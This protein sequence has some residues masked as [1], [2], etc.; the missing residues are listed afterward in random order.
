MLRF[1]FLGIHR[2][3]FLFSRCF[4]GGKDGL[5]EEGKT[6]FPSHYTAIIIPGRLFASPAYGRQHGK[7][8]K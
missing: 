6:E 7:A 8:S 3:H 4:C 5:I 2:L 1:F